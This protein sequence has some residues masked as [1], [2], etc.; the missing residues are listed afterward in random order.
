[1]FAHFHR[2]LTPSGHS[3]MS[4]IVE[5]K[6]SWVRP[7]STQ[8]S[9]YVRCLL[10]QVLFGFVTSF[11]LT[12]LPPPSASCPPLRF[13]RRWAAALGWAALRRFESDWDG[14]GWVGLTDCVG[15]ALHGQGRCGA[16]PQFGDMDGECLV[17]VFVCVCVCVCVCLWLVCVGIYV[18]KAE[19]P[20]EKQHSKQGIK[21]ARGA[22]SWVGRVHNM[23]EW[24]T[25]IST[26]YSSPSRPTPAGEHASHNTPRPSGS[27]KTRTC[28]GS[29]CSCPFVVFI[30]FAFDLL[31]T[32]RL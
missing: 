4:K 11:L 21:V 32:K 14:M 3:F 26:R 9:Y 2:P 25:A 18:D 10:N 12:L 23:V 24:S 27:S 5:Q 19:T 13:A 31:T 7:P 29:V 30:R 8:Y 20:S 6:H 28:G 22:P 16:K 15:R 17:C 1:M